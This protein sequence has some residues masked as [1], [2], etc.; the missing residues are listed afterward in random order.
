M[1][2]LLLAL[3]SATSV[4][5]HTPLCVEDLAIRVDTITQVRE[6]SIERAAARFQKVPAVSFDNI[7]VQ[8]KVHQVGEIG[9]KALME[10]LP[11]GVTFTSAPAPT[12]VDPVATFAFDEGRS[13]ALNLEFL[14]EGRPTSTTAYAFLPLPLIQ[15]TGG[16]LVNKAQYKAVLV[17]GHGG[18]TPNGTGGNASSIA[19]EV[20]KKGIPTLA[21]DL[22]G[23]G[24]GPK[25]PHGFETFEKQAWWFVEAIEKLVEPGVQIN[26]SGHSWGAMF[27]IWLHR[28]SD[29]PR[30]KNFANYISLSPAVDVTL[31]GNIE[32]QIAFEQKYQS[33]YVNFK[34]RIAD[35]DF[36]FLNNLLDNGKDSDIGAYFTALTSMD[37][38]T[39]PLTIEQQNK[40]KPLTVVV[41]K[42][43]GLVYVGREDQYDKAFGNLQG[44]SQYIVLDKGITW[45]SK[46]KD[47]L[48]DIGHQTFDLRESWGGPYVVYGIISKLVLDGGP[49]WSVEESTGDKAKDLIEKYFRNY[50]NFFGF[51]EMLKNRVEH[52]RVDTDA[53]PALVKRQEAL[54]HFVSKTTELQKELDRV[55]TTKEMLPQV[56]AAIEELR[57]RVGISGR[58]TLKRAHE[59]LALPDISDERK[60]ELSAYV[61]EIRKKE[62]EIDRTFVDQGFNK[63]VAEL[64]VEF[65]SSLKEAGIASVVDYKEKFAELNKIPKNQRTDAQEELRKSFGRL[66]QKISKEIGM[67]GARRQAAKD[68][69]Y[70]TIKKPEGISDWRVALREVEANRSEAWRQKLRHFIA[71]Y[72][73]VE[74]YAF[75]EVVNDL[76]KK[77]AQVRRVEGVEDLKMAAEEAKRLKEVIDMRFVPEGRND[78]AAVMGEIKATEAE[79]EKLDKGKPE[80]M[81]AAKTDQEKAEAMK[82][83]DLERKADTLRLSRASSLKTWEGLWTMEKVSAPAVTAAMG[84]YN[85]IRENYRE[86]YYA[87]EDQ[88]SNLLLALKQRNRLS[89]DNILKTVTELIKAREAKQAAKKE[90]L[91]AKSELD[92]LRVREGLAGNLAGEAEDVKTAKEAINLLYGPDNITQKSKTMDEV[93]AKR[94]ARI[95]SANFEANELRMKYLKLMRQSNEPLAYNI[96]R[97]NVW[98]AL[99]QPLS[100]LIAAMSSDR[101]KKE[102]EPILFT[103]LNQT[104]VRWESMLAKFRAETQPKDGNDY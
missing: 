77:I 8:A 49:G 19:K 25:D 89:G 55:L 58:M 11:T 72:N 65:A 29:N 36:Q 27:V 18:G 46:H 59:E 6:R 71:Q 98:Q 68:E 45:K 75:N 26:L 37:Y 103:A 83:A 10:F 35:A 40:L 73:M 5:A 80:A 34:S 63:L 104:M 43:D 52:V 56:A 1:H 48:Q 33:E 74:S 23:H 9:P 21:I 38:F 67:H 16:F 69:A 78:I 102:R 90:F 44:K 100:S 50:S 14:W 101:G 42:H 12:S 3:I 97:V 51:R 54:E 39:P 81:K 62:A 47:D 70:A 95:A 22:P 24:T 93:L 41:G 91:K 28:N 32:D 57:E 17:H 60:A 76:K 88:K 7:E 66:E 2:L 96:E 82:L 53:R 30:L 92:A 84:N 99:D 31:G 61:A 4:F 20:G 79:I 13:I 87:Y 94:Q 15:Q 64:N 85:R 86:L